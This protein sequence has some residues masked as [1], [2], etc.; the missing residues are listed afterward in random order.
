MLGGKNSNFL[1]TEG[2][3]K[4]VAP[5]PIK[6]ASNWLKG[7][8]FTSEFPLID[9]SQAAP[10]SQ[11]PIALRQAVADF[12]LN[13]PKAHLY[14][15]ILGMPALRTALAQKW[16][17]SYEAEISQN[18]IAITAG[19]N[20]AFCT[21][22]ATIANEGDEVILP[23]PWY[24]NHKM[25]LD[26]MGIKTVPLI[27]RGSLRPSC[28]EAAKLVTNKTKAIVLVNP[29]NPTGLEYSDALLKDF[30][31]LAQSENIAL[32]I[33]ETYRDFSGKNGMSHSLLRNPDWT[34]TLI[35]LYSFS[36]VY[37]LTGHRVGAIICSPCRMQAIEKFLDTV[38]ICPS[39]VGQFAALWGVENLTAWVI[40]QKE[41]I[42][43]KQSFVQEAFGPLSDLGWELLGCGAYFTYL[44]HPFDLPSHLVAKKMV[45]QAAL[46][47]LPGEMFAPKQYRSAQQHLR[48]A[49]ANVESANLKTSLER[50]TNFRL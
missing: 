24:F 44:K 35:Q 19:C 20:Q 28:K 5:A 12:V 49:F 33:D 23:V 29:N 8:E 32:I 13:D 6:E 34:K 40:E 42:I 11:P 38:T 21:A 7:L 39:Q 18:N 41:K 9:L 17:Q 25:W 48:I 14:G 22:I 26:M 30:F 37:R 50:L 1:N 10:S 46:L 4:S 43:E 47:A 27:P 36:K 31:D 2:R 15:D 16:S 3:T 45:Q